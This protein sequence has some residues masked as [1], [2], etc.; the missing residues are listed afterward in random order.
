[1]LRSLV[2]VTLLT[3]PATLSAQQESAAQL[4]DRGI[5]RMGGDSILRSVRTIRFEM[6]TQWLTITFADR[7][8]ADRPSYE[9]HVDLRDYASASW[10]NTRY[11]NPA[12]ATPG[13]VDVVR[14]TIAARLMPRAQGA[15]PSWGPLNLA[16]VDERRELFAF[17]PERLLPALRNDRTVRRLADTIID[18]AVHHRLAATVDGWPAVAFLRQSDALPT[19]VRFR[20]DETN[21]FG[22]APWAE[23]EVEFWYSNWGRHASG[24]VFPR[25]RD[26]RRVGKPYKRMTVLSV[27]VNPEAPADSFAISDS[28]TAA[29]LATERRPMWQTTLDGAARLEREAFAV[30][31][32]MVG[33]LGAVRIG[34]RWI[35]LEAA[36]SP[37]AMALVA[38]WLDRNGGGAPI[39]GAIAANVFTGNGGA[40]W[41]VSRKLPIHVAPGAAATLATITGQRTGFTTVSTSRWLR[42]GTDSLWL[43]PLTVPDMQGTMMVYSPTLRWAWAPFIGSPTHGPEQ[44]ALITRLEARGLKVDLIGGAR[45]IATP[46]TP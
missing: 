41:F 1:M 38:D 23:H 35:V 3:C 32:P 10:R 43:E 42:V 19:L 5:S 34:G 33:A 2:V 24:L 27:M 17:A 13:V 15:A 7:P 45:A 36:Q 11:F 6:L 21:D 8:F 46:R 40:P 37:G 44:Q 31:P 18:G 9:R 26:V 4:L 25:Q 22:L 29:Y 16:Y 14:D 12:A 39:G 30:L 28:V 20:A